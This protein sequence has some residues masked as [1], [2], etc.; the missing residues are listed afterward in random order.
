MASAMI[1]S[2]DEVDFCTEVEIP[3]DIR[4]LDPCK[5]SIYIDDA[6]LQKAM[7]WQ[8]YEPMKVQID[9]RLFVIPSRNI[10]DRLPPIKFVKVA[11]LE[12]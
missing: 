1:G 3:T 11:S 10:E 9:R 4:V 5:L 8:M 6:K 7:Q 12:I 2:E